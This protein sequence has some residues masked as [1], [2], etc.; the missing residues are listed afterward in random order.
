[1]GGFFVKSKNRLKE[2][3]AQTAI[4]IS[5]STLNGA[6]FKVEREIRMRSQFQPREFANASLGAKN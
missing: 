2:L 6:A 3:A 1:M 5:R 4:R